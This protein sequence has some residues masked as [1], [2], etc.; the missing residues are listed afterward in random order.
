MFALGLLAEVLVLGSCRLGKHGGDDL[1]A[2][3]GDS[4]SGLFF[5]WAD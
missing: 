2:F 5:H 4:F 3:E 1:V